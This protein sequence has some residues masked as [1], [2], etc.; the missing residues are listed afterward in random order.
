MTQDKII[1]QLHHPGTS[2]PPICLSDHPIGSNTKSTWTPEELHRIT[3]CRRFHNYHHIID[4]SK[5]GHLIDTGEF[6]ISLGSYTTIPKAPRG[7]L[8]DRTLSY[9]LDIVHADITFQDCASIGGY[10]HALVFVNHAT[11]YNWTFGLKS[12]QHDDIIVAFMAFQDEAGS[13]AHQ[14]RCD[15]NEKLFGNSVW[16]FLHS[17]KSLIISSP[18]GRQSGNGLVKAHWK[19]MVHMS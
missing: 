18:A 14:F 2:L 3:G 19:I 15:C 4:T 6:P 12:L 5:D 7:K 10:K 8:I 17:N 16:S 9:Y 1:A 13:L 11:R